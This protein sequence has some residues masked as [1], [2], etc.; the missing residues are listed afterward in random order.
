MWGKGVEGYNYIWLV[1]V[2]C[3]ILLPLERDLKYCI[4]IHLKK[5]IKKWWLLY[6]S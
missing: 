5:K 3:N 4:C 1:H 6:L 2:M